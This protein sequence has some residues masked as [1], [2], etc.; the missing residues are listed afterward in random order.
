MK[1]IARRISC[2]RRPFIPY[3][4]PHIVHTDARRA[5]D[6]ALAAAVRAAGVRAAALASVRPSAVG[7]CRRPSAALASALDLLTHCRRR[8]SVSVNLAAAR[9]QTFDTSAAVAACRRAAEKYRRAALASI[10]AA[11]DRVAADTIHAAAV[12]PLTLAALYAA[13]LVVPS[14]A[15]MIAR[16]A[17]ADARRR[18]RLARKAAA[19][20]HDESKVK[21]AK[22]RRRSAEEI[23]LTKNHAAHAETIAPPRTPSALESLAYRAA[24]RGVKTALKK[25]GAD[26]MRVLLSEVRAFWTD[27]A[28][29]CAAYN[30]GAD[31]VQAAAAAILSAADELTNGNASRRAA[32]I[33]KTSGK[34]KARAVLASPSAT[35]LEKHAAAHG[36]DEENDGDEYAPDVRAVYYAG[37]HA[38]RNAIYS[39]RAVRGRAAVVNE[40]KAAESP[41]YITDADGATYTHVSGKDVVLERQTAYKIEFISINAAAPAAPD[42]VSAWTVGETIATT[43]AA[44]ADVDALDFFR[45]ALDDMPRDIA[46]AARAVYL[47]GMTPKDAAAVLRVSPATLY[48]RL[49]AAR[50]ALA[51]VYRAEG[52]NIA[53]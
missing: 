52:Y 10:R 45:A 16:K 3:A 46:R 14:F 29:A 22:S 51:S 12:R 1:N 24:V 50:A 8:P 25:S 23:A 47:D 21:A 33:E 53:D 2:R 48:R 4:A 34:V 39:A 44:A 17:A 38:V 42:D 40:R 37:L 49:T 31:L 9:P 6:T 7:V 30:R 32:L 41:V 35:P 15:A 18:A 13:P 36:N 19:A 11:A 43:D 20:G 26:D 27:G 5:A 28:D